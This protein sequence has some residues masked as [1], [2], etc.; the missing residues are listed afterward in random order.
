MHS[1]NSVRATRSRVELSLS[2][3]AISVSFL[4]NDHLNVTVSGEC[5]GL[6]I[7]DEDRVL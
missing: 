1:E 6:R 2:K 4:T 3:S 5:R 7:Q